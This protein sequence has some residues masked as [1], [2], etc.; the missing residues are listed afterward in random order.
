MVLVTVGKR[1]SDQTQVDNSLFPDDLRMCE[2][3]VR[4]S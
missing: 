2:G 1:D 4:K 3:S